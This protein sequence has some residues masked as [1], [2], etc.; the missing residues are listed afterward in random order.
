MSKQV[1]FGE[2]D[3]EAIE[4]RNEYR[5]TKLVFACLAAQAL[6]LSTFLKWLFEDDLW[7]TLSVGAYFGLFV[8][9]IAYLFI[10]YRSRV[11]ITGQSLILKRPLFKD[12][13]IAYWEVGEVQVNGMVIRESYNDDSGAI[14]LSAARRRWPVA[15]YSMLKLWSR[16][17]K[18]KI[19]VHQSLESFD[20]FC[21]DLTERWRSAID[22]YLGYAKGT[23]LR[24]P[25][26]YLNARET[27][28][29]QREEALLKARSSSE[30]QKVGA[31]K[32]E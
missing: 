2:I 28:K 16:D 30:I 21:D 22:R 18:R 19:N 6:S 31:T 9:L 13:E 15:R 4:Y 3:F 20:R 32:S 25:E 12:V 8:F 11:I 27:L 7:L 5:H 23:S 26:R 10:Q 14:D 29:T 17:R 24:Q 1:E